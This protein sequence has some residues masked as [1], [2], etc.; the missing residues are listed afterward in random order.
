MDLGLKGRTA[1]ITGASKGIGAGVARALAREG[2][3]LH[4]AARSA[5]LLQ[6]LADELKQAH[7]IR[8]ETHAMDISDGKTPAELL[9]RTGTPDP[10]Q[11]RGRHSG[12]RHRR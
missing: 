1:L 9:R 7:G 8:A 5:P 6:A 3:N 11:Q 12:R 4:L 2:V 10:D